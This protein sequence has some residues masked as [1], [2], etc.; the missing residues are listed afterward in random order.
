[1]SNNDSEKTAE[2]QA[3]I[4]ELEGD[5]SRDPRAKALAISRA[6]YIDMPRQADNLRDTIE[7]RTR[8]LEEKTHALENVE[9]SLESKCEELRAAEAKLAEVTRLAT[10][11][12]R[13]FPF[14]HVVAM[15]AM[16]YLRENPKNHIDGRRNSDH[17]PG[18]KTITHNG[19]VAWLDRE[20]YQRDFGDVVSNG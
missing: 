5:I 13:R 11:P 19:D 20:T 9:R 15:V 4:R 12:K 17:R 6:L 18:F 3:L 2:M 1:M 16:D 14:A 10:G 8:L 7:H